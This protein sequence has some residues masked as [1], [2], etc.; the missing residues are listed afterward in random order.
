M[1]EMAFHE[2]ALHNDHVQDAEAYTLQI[3]SIE[4]RSK[5]T[6][7]SYSCLGSSAEIKDLLLRWQGC[8][9]S[10]RPFRF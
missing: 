6:F 9:V 5:Q 1:S 7:E 10:L 8:A 2:D 3:D 4:Q